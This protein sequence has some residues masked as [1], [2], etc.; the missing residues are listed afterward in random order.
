MDASVSGRM[1]PQAPP[2]LPPRCLWPLE[3]LELC[4]ASPAAAMPSSAVESA[5]K[6]RG[7]GLQAL[8][9]VPLIPLPL[10]VPVYP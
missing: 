8:S 3:L 5:A 1:G 6:A 10:C 4:V 2:L 7:P 9:A